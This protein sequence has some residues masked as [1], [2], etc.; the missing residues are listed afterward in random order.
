MAGGD[1]AGGDGDIALWRI[2]PSGGV[3][4]RDGGEPALGGPGDQSVDRRHRR[5][6]RRVTLAGSDYGRVGLWE[7]DVLDR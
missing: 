1:T 2:D 6:G 3:T 5:R 4:R 7:S